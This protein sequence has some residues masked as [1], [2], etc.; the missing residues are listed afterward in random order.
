MPA[1]TAEH[2]VGVLLKSNGEALTG[3]DRRANDIADSLAK[4]AALG[5]RLGQDLLDRLQQEAAE[6]TE[7]A[8]WL[9][10]VT[11][12][13]NSFPLES[14]GTIRDSLAKAG[15][16]SSSRR[17]RKRAAEPAVESPRESAR[18]RLFKLPRLAAVR[19]RVLARAA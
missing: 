14:G 10:K 2:D 19:E 17:G 9:A 5:R 16:S 13:A 12:R 11:V 3:A 8:V 4:A 18:E 15:A 7:M 1:H 6:V